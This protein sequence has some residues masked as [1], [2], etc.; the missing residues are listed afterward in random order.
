MSVS[1]ICEICED[2][3]AVDRCERCGAVVC[4]EHVAT[5]LGYCTR[6]ASEVRGG[7]ADPERGEDTFRF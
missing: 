4:R 6:C 3:P 7:D 1:G 5:E 2:A